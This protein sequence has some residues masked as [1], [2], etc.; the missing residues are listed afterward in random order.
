MNPTSPNHAL[1]HAVRLY[2]AAIEKV[3]W[4]Q[5]GGFFGVIGDPALEALRLY[6]FESLEGCFQY[7]EASE[8]AAAE[9]DEIEYFLSEA[10]FQYSLFGPMISALQN[11]AP[12]VNSHGGTVFLGS[13]GMGPAEIGWSIRYLNE[14]HLFERYLRCAG[15]SEEEVTRYDAG[16]MEDLNDE[17]R[18]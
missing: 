5:R 13:W 6:S 14:R 8:L 10:K 7:A 12:R 9:A 11:V 2:T 15:V 18:A 16:F 4:E 17:S 3:S 1:Q